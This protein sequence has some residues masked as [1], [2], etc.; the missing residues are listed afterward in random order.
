ME[1]EKIFANHLSDKGLISKICKELISLNSKTLYHSKTNKSPNNLIKKWTEGLNR[2]YPKKVNWYIGRCFVVI[3]QSLSHVW[4]FVTSWTVVPQAP[5]SSHVSQSLF[6]L[7]S[8]E[9]VMLYNQLILSCPF[10][11]CLQ[12][13]PASG[14]FPMSQLFA[15]GGQSTG[16][17]ATVLPMNTQG[18][19]PLGSLIIREM[20]TKTTM[21]YCLT[22]V[23]M[24]IIKKR[25]QGLYP[26]GGNVNWFIHYGKW[27]LILNRT[28]IHS[29]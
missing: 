19:F 9:S 26:G 11:F 5:L 20:Q 18:W 23:R 16:A 3:V 17:S 4:L 14:A 29:T 27:H 8:I 10:S 22:S 12:S 25:Q 21:S 2:H 1:W 13:F 24:V 7:M 15:S 28:T 6:K